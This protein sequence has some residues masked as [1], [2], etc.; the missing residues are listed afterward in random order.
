[1]KIRALLVSAVS[2]MVAAGVAVAAQHGAAAA[3]AA[4]T[5]A[6]PAAAKKPAVKKVSVSGSV[7]AVDAAAGKLSV[8]DKKGAV[9][10]LVVAADAKIKRSGK[11]A[12][13]AEVMVGDKVMSAKGEDVNG[14][15]TI[16]KLDVK[17]PKAAATK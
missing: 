11:A 13:L 8:K 6:A 3:P 10:E 5:A 7:E 14:V 4:K 12:T 2:L 15:A 9:V 16:K 1:M 17:A